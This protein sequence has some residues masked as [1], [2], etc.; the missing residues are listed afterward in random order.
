MR[1]E[2]EL[3]S[4]TGT[5]ICRAVKKRAGFD[6]EDIN[7]IE[8]APRAFIPALFGHARGDTFVKVHHT[9]RLH[10]AYAGEKELII[11][12]DCDHNSP[13]P[14]LFY[15][16]VRSFLRCALQLS[17]NTPPDMQAML[18]ATND[19]DVGVFRTQLSHTI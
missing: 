14:T 12:D 5:T 3:R 11:F 15:E 16:T 13:R 10:E 8:Y 6:I 2:P 18:Q 7:P 9:E 1:V 17:Q 4:Y 19:A